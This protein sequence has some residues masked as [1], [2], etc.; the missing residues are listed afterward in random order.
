MG[1]A[2]GP[3]AAGGSI[4]GTGLQAFGDVEKAEGTKAA[5]TMQ[6][7]ELA[8]KAQIGRAQADETNANMLD[9]LNQSLGTIAAVRA[10]GHDY[11]NSPTGV[12]LAARTTQ[13]NNESR[14]TQI[15]NIESQVA[16]DEAGAAYLRNAGSFALD[17]GYL[18]AATDVAKGISSTFKPTGA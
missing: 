15:G 2:A 7:D 9:R 18:S 3:I 8:E 17:M 16:Q 11:P 5:D 12:A 13:L 6:A 1:E 4:V 14:L 10:A